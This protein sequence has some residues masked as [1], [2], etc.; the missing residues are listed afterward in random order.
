MDTASSTNMFVIQPNSTVPPPKIGGTF[1]C[2]KNSFKDRMLPKH[3][4]Q[5]TLISVIFIFFYYPF[6]CHCFSL[7]LLVPMQWDGDYMTGTS[8]SKNCL[9]F[10][11]NELHAFYAFEIILYVH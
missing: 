7:L 9:Y 11:K 5:S 1:K 10:L 6:S 2:I 4:Q 3:I 8:T